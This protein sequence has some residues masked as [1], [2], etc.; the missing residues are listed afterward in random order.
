[1]PRKTSLLA[2]AGSF[3]AILGAASAAAGAV[4]VHRAPRARDLRTLGIDPAAFKNIGL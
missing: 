3:F 4:E 1:M 2:H